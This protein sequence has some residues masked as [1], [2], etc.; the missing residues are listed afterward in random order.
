[1]YLIAES[2]DNDRRLITA[3]D[4]GGLGMD[5]QWNDDFHHALRVALTGQRDGYYI[6]YAGVAD[7]CKALMQGYVY[8]G[9]FSPFRQRRHGSSP[10]GLAGSRF[11]VFSQNHDQIGNRALGD[12]LS[13][14]V[15]LGKVKVAAAATLLAPFL[16]LLFMGEEYGEAAPFPY[17]VSH[18]D[19]S[20]V[21]A[22]RKG[23]R[24]EFAAFGWQGEIPDPQDEATFQSAKLDHGLRQGGNHAAL[25]DYYRELIRFRRNTACLGDL[26]LSK[27]T[28]TQLGDSNALTLRRWNDDSQV[29]VL[30]N[31][32][33]SGVPPFSLPDGGWTM[34]IDSNDPRWGGSATRSA[35]SS[36]RVAA[37]NEVSL[38]PATVLVFTSEHGIRA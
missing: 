16:P 7:V 33:D 13:H 26:D 1:I 3:P 27:T 4:H 24:E 21:E 23:R 30:L 29:L 35:P 34:A 9:Q 28:V 17:F 20:L 31:L 5:G 6:D 36:R 8:T 19:P 38:P 10:T 11:M 32:G 12:R 14:G 25:R 22:V 37:K 2:S 15:S 18:S